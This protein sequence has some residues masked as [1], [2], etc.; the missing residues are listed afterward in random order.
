MKLFQ[1]FILLLLGICMISFHSCAEDED[2]APVPE[3]AVE[4]SITITID[5]PTNDAVVSNCEDVHIQV[6]FDASIENHEVEIVLHPEGDTSNKL[7][8]YDEH[9]HDKEISFVQD[10]NLCDFAAGTCFHLEVVACINHD[11]DQAETADAE[12]C[13]P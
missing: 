13:L 6:D 11:C 12:F 10:I 3:P 1:P 4:N 2:D 8:D 7:I 5:E 9:N